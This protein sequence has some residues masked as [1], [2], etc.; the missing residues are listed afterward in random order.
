M[1]TEEDCKDWKDYPTYEEE[2]EIVG[3][4]SKLNI[5]TSSHA[6][7]IYI[8]NSCLPEDYRWNQDYNV[9][10]WE[11]SFVLNSSQEEDEFIN[12]TKGSL[13]ELGYELN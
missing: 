7:E 11:F 10:E 8:P 4:F 5:A 2:F 12:M 3:L 13:Q 6:L 9:R 1:T